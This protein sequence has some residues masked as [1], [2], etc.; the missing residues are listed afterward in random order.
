MKIVGVV[1]AALFLCAVF[2]YHMCNIAN[3][4]IN[5][6]DNNN[7]PCPPRNVA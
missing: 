2:V 4:N 3:Y 6:N 5:N 7:E 1:L